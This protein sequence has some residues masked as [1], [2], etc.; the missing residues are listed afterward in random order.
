MKAEIFIQFEK[1]TRDE[2]KHSRVKFNESISL[3]CV[4]E[5]HPYQLTHRSKTVGEV[6]EQIETNNRRNEKGKR[7]K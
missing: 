4:L 1:S 3:S 7:L 5:R 2:F 6:Y